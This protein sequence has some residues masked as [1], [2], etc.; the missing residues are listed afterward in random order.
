MASVAIYADSGMGKTMLMQHFLDQHK[1]AFDRTAGIERIPVLSMQMVSRPSE[2][3]FYTQIMDIIG[4][5]PNPRISLVDLEVVALRMLKHIDLK[6]LLIDEA[7]NILA[8]T[9][10]EQRA[11]LNLL[12]F[13]SNEL[14]VSVVCFG[15]AD[16]KEAISG[17][18]QL[19]RRFQEY[20]LPRW[21]AD[22]EFQGLVIGVRVT[23][24]SGGLRSCLRGPKTRPSSI[25]RHHFS[26][27][28]NVARSPNCGDTVRTGVH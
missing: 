19:A 24:R 27:C 13:I 10:N 21:K 4:A 14:R 2:K 12:R 15:V 16:A 23:Y 6:M 28:R 8:A 5:P 11:M 9:Y 20:A 1:A 22:E 18:A 25:R 3:R 7:H 17:D 26:H